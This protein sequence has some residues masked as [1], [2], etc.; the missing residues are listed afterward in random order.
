M[1]S[2]TG[3]L[4][5]I[6]GSFVSYIESMPDGEIAT[7][8][9]AQRTDHG[10]FYPQADAS[11]PLEFNGSVHFTGHH[12]L[13]AVSIETPR[14]RCGLE[15]WSLEIRDPFAPDGWLRFVEFESMTLREDDRLRPPDGGDLPR[16]SEDG[17]DL[18]FD[19]YAPGTP[20]DA[21]DVV[22][23]DELHTAGIR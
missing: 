12:G 11:T 18:F 7:T 17:A 21:L 2:R 4:W 19:Q 20:L 5:S 1:H 14:L 23:L 15:G 8:D 16:L 3:L 6:K 10:F 22:R 9:G 13:L